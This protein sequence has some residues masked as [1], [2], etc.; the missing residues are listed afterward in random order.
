MYIK[1]RFVKY[2]SLNILGMIGLSCYI[3]ADTFFISRAQ[4]ADGLTA[5]NL[6]LPI[7]NFIFAIGAMIGVGSAICFAIAKS[8]RDKDV[9]SYFFQA[10]FF[11]TLFGVI[12]SILGLAFPDKILALLGADEGILSIGVPYT[13]IF[14]GFAPVFMWNHVV[15]AFVRNDGAP[16]VAMNATLFSSLFN[17]VF[18]YILMFPLQMGMRGAALATALS[19]VVGI[20]VCSL[21][22]FSGKS[23]VHFKPAKPSL[24]RL[25]G[26]CR[27]GVSAF[28]GEVAS[29]IILI[30]FNFLILRLAGNVGVAAY[31][32]V[33]NTA[34][35]AVAVFNGISQGSQPL[36]SEAYGSGRMQEVTWLKRAALFSAF[37]LASIMYMVLFACTSQIV[38]VF[39]SEKNEI[40][41]ELARNGMHLY[42]IGLFFAGINIVGGSYFSAVEKAREAFWISILR[43]FLLIILMAFLMACIWGLNGVWLS[44]AAAEGLTFMVLVFCMK[45]KGVKNPRK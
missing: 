3:L 12:F 21:R 44:Y 7:Y 20:L 24:L 29:G 10:I 8:R 42:F 23:S 30:V 1:K 2:V 22:L 14:M 35:V 28:V 25:W 5:L 41:G 31:G 19:P 18:D 32:V 34:I 45:K 9:D 15:N 33:A 17:I 40:M 43:G 11:T 16:T 37:C 13:R 27:L 36:I 6:A 26:A 39:N 4:G 38:A